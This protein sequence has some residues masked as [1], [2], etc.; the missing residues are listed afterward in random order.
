MRTRALG[1]RGH[2][3][4]LSEELAF[5]VSSHSIMKKLMT[6]Q[7]FSITQQVRCAVEGRVPVSRR[8][9]RRRGQPRKDGS[10]GR[11]GHGVVPGTK[12]FNKGGLEDRR[13]GSSP[14][15]PFLLWKHALWGHQCLPTRGFKFPVKYSLEV[16]SLATL[17][18]FCC[19]IRDTRCQGPWKLNSPQN[20]R[21]G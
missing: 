15:F 11:P 21:E 18:F 7:G 19:H 3:H 10:L 6:S 13:N 5:S 20:A 17:P 9:S 16:L 8:E 2:A 12:I 4:W 14:L 1:A